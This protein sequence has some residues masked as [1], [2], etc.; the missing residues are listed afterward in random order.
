MEQKYLYI[1]FVLFAPVS[2]KLDDLGR[3]FFWLGKKNSTT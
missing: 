1:E 3:Q 2:S